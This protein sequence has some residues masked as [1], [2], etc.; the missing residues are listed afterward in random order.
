MPVEQVVHDGVTYELELSSKP[1]EKNGGYVGVVKQGNHFHAKITIFKGDGQ[2]MLPGRGC[3]T[4]QE[5]ALRLA[6]YKAEP[7]D[8][9]KKNPE[10]APKGAAKVRSTRLSIRPSPRTHVCALLLL[11]EAQS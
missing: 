2:T 8:I 6:M 11:T 10:R 4:A 5:A 9:E 1:S 3:C 7:Y